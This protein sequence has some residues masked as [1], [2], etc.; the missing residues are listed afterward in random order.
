[1]Q[2][3]PTA[4]DTTRVNLLNQLAFAASSSEPTASFKYAKEALE[5]AR[6]LNFQRGE[7]AALG[8]IGTFYERF[9]DYALALEYKLQALRIS[10]RINI[11]SS[12]ARS[13]NSIGILYFR[14]KKYEQALEYY[15]KALQLAQAQNLQEAVA[16][17]LLNIGEVYQEMGDYAKAIAYEEK[18]MKISQLDP[19]MQDCIAFSRGIIGKCQLAQK[20]YKQALAN[21]EASIRIFRSIDDQ[22]SV[23]EYLIQLAKVHQRLKN[24]LRA[25]AAL[26]EAIAI[27]QQ[28]Q[29]KIFEK[30]ACQALAEVYAS[31]GN[32]KEA[33]E[34]Q[35]QYLRLYETIF[36]ENSDRRMLQMQ[37][38]YEAEKKQAEIEILQ[39][40]KQLK[41]EEARIARIASYFF[42][43]LVLMSGVLLGVVIR[44]NRQ[45]QR[46]NRLLVEK[47]NEIA[48]K[49]MELEQQKEELLAQSSLV[50]EQNK[51]LQ[52]Q[53]EEIQNHRNAITASINYAQRIQTALLPSRELL[54]QHLGEAFVFYRPRD[55]V[56]GDFYYFAV[57]GQNQ[58]VIIAA[59][60]CTG[61]GVP[62]ALMSMIGNA[63]LN[64]LIEVQ[65]MSAPPQILEALHQK[66]RIMLRQDSSDNRDGMDIALCTIDTQVQQLYFAGAKSD[67]YVVHNNTLTV[68]RGDRLSIGGYQPEVKRDFTCHPVPISPGMRFYLTT[69][70][71]KD[72]F[73]GDL[74]KKF[75]AN[76]FKEMLMQVQVYPMHE[77]EYVIAQIFDNWKN[78][79][80]Q[81]DDVLVIGWQWKGA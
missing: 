25:I 75:S 34:Y 3:L 59:I 54:V 64:Q 39:K 17:Y 32:F 72:Q 66:V 77:Q 40:D 70:G 81:T 24:N 29:N 55:I 22:A 76:R 74:Q 10:E 78:G 27:S 47:N 50:E 30:D 1:M 8:I 46:A 19:N 28:L 45:K 73:G 41:E 79:Q 38:I 7:S 67:L 69:D 71:F 12:L 20:Q 18:S 35:Q 37:T 14:Q 58:S 48:Q 15:Q 4:S 68:I 44:N 33:F 56:S 11:R 49:N 16:V 65:G 51:V 13:Y 63:I 21:I 43:A 9:G 23:A 57:V 26:Q 53:N 42:L 60:D 62:G 52:L 80:P 5:L 6:Q 36:N 61:H 2:I 31:Q